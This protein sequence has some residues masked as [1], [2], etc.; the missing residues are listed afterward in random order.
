MTYAQVQ[1]SPSPHSPHM[2]VGGGR[3]GRAGE[4]GASNSTE[5]YVRAW[6]TRVR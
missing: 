6:R 1:R 4:V 5:L 3:G 2:T